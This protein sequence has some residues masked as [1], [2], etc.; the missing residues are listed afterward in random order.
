VRLHR[1]GYDLRH[2]S[3]LLG[4]GTLTATKQLI[5]SDPVKLGD[6]VASVI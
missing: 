5:E 4:H 6:L 2:I 3:E 1:R